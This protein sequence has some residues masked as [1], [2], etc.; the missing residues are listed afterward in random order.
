MLVLKFSQLRYLL[1]CFPDTP[2]N[3][4]I[5]LEHR[6][7]FFLCRHCLSQSSTYELKSDSFT[8]AKLPIVVSDDRILG[9]NLFIS[10]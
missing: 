8:V 6:T 9:G 3:L 7:N 10:Q 2:S 1:L 5:L 4:S